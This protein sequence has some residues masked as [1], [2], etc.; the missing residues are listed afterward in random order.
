MRCALILSWAEQAPAPDSTIDV[1]PFQA[2]A[3]D[4]PCAELHNRL[5]LIDNTMVFWERR[6]RCADSAY[7]HTLFG[8]RREQVLCEHYDSL[9]GPLTRCYDERYQTLFETIIANL[10]SSD[11]GLGTDHHVEQIAICT[12]TGSR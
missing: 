7:N 6:G 8:K 1:K 4:A 5:F 9:I 11:L 2:L 10:H 12:N 3:R